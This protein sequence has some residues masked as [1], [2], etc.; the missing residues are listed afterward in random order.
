M[1]DSEATMTS[2]YAAYLAAVLDGAMPAPPPAPLAVCGRIGRSL[3]TASP[4]TPDLCGC[5]AS[6]CCD[7]D[8]SGVCPTWWLSTTTPDLVLTDDTTD[9]LAFA[10]DADG[11]AE[12][13][14]W[15]QAPGGSYAVLRNLGFQH[16]YIAEKL[17]AGYVFYIFVAPAAS[18][19]LALVQADWDGV[20]DSVRA[21][22]SAEVWQLIEPHLEV[23]RGVPYQALMRDLLTTVDMGELRRGGRSHPGYIGD[24]WLCRTAASWSPHD[25][26]DATAGAISAHAAAAALADPP[27]GVPVVATTITACDAD[28][29]RS[30]AAYLA[31]GITP[32]YVRA[33][34]YLEA[35][36]RELF[37]GDGYT[38]PEMASGGDAS[39]GVAE[40]LVHNVSRD[41]IDDLHIGLTSLPAPDEADDGP[42]AVL[43]ASA[44]A[45]SS[46]GGLAGYPATTA[47]DVSYN[48]LAAIHPGELAP[49]A[50]LTRVNLSHNALADA[51]PLAK[52]LACADGLADLDL[53][54]NSLADAAPLGALTSLVSLNLASNTLRT[55]GGLASLSG[56]ASLDVRAN[57]L[58]HLD[59]VREVAL[60]TALMVPSLLRVDIHGRPPSPRRA[61]PSPSRRSAETRSRKRRDSKAGPRRRGFAHQVHV[62][63]AEKQASPVRT[64]SLSAQLMASGIQPKSAFL[65]SLLDASPSPVKAASASAKSRRGRPRRAQAAPAPVPLDERPNESLDGDGEP[66]LDYVAIHARLARA[67]VAGP[68]HADS[69]HET[70]ESKSEA[71]VPRELYEAAL[72]KSDELEQRVLAHRQALNAVVEYYTQREAARDAGEDVGCAAAPHTLVAPYGVSIGPVGGGLASES[73][74]AKWVAS[75]GAARSS[76]VGGPDRDA[77]IESVA[78]LRAALF[79]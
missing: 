46:L 2:V 55:L 31:T 47:L 54:H 45:L 39:L 13:A 68:P 71:S 6:V 49:L 1:A 79:V 21:V 28:F 66:Q 36:L 24:A 78:R 61:A 14:A 34:F 72:R 59:D 11:M 42:V 20:A 48:A 30:R 29:A 43:N 58:S 4:P 12:I 8:S 26:D 60:N 15:A 64:P 57:L 75:P 65:R 18:P 73:T 27:A 41:C 70:R 37:R 40:Y 76:A 17:A 23:V 63:S 53:S 52:G 77:L 19:A 10:C 38:H 67:T 22:Y 25:A 69:E 16:G 50:G 74:P 44:N 32:A 51:G 5:D 62:L 33:F 35:G 56:L 9:R 3:T 7:A